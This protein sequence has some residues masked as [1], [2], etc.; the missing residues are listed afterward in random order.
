MSRGNDVGPSVEAPARELV[1]SGFALETADAPLLHDWL[2]M[3]DL[4]HLLRARADIA[5]DDQWQLQIG[6]EHYSGPQHSLF[7]QLKANSLAYLQVR[8][9]F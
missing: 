7:G 1:E 5:I 8:R 4:A 9:G 2:N 3:A 6:G